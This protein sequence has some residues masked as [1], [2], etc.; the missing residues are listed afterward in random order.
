MRSTGAIE[1]AL[2]HGTEV[3]GRVLVRH[4]L[5]LPGRAVRLALTS[6]VLLSEEILGIQDQPEDDRWPMRDDSARTGFNSSHGTT[7]RGLDQVVH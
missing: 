7:E 6:G 5:A 4:R 3:A 2:Q 1:L